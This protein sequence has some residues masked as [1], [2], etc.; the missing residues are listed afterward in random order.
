[1]EPVKNEAEVEAPN[2]VMELNPTNNSSSVTNSVKVTLRSIEGF[3][4]VDKNKN[5]ER[6][7]GDPGIPDV[8]IALSGTDIFNMPVQKDTVT[9]SD[10]SYAFNNLQPGGYTI[11]Q[12]PPAG[13]PDG[14]LVMGKGAVIDPTI[15]DHV[16]QNLVLGEAQDATDYDFRQ[17]RPNFSKRLYLAST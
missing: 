14:G 2:G 7:P 6:D 17:L 8:D 9:E 16:F 4:F 11:T 3:V 10:G 15:A 1:M 5:G 13:F 12:T